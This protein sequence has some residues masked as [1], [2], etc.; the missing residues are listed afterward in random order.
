MRVVC[1]LQ[2]LLTNTICKD[3][4]N[5]NNALFK[6]IKSGSKNCVADFFYTTL[7][8]VK[9][10]KKYFMLLFFLLLQD[11][12]RMEMTIWRKLQRTY[13]TMEDVLH[14]TPSMFEL[15][16]VFAVHMH[17]IMHKWEI[18]SNALAEED[19]EK[20]FSSVLDLWI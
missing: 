2:M 12:R 19:F 13:L 8:Q 4:Y 17:I 5:M 9:H 10:M 7:S 20:V 18:R 15:C 11:P 6:E 14:H 16:N 3:K 1:F